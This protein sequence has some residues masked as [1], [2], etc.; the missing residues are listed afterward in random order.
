[1]ST[2]TPYSLLPKAAILRPLKVPPASSSASVS[3]SSQQPFALY[4][5]LPTEIL[6]ALREGSSEVKINIASPDSIVR[7]FFFFSCFGLGTLLTPL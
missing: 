2:N 3:A 7:T 4:M 1:M 6:Q 5:K